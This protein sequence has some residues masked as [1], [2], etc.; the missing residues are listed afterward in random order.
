MRIYFLLLLFLSFSFS[1]VAQT[2]SIVVK[3]IKLTIVGAGALATL[4]G[5]YVYIQKSWW[6]DNASEFHFDDGS[7]LRYA[8][9][10]DKAGHFVG[11]MLISDMFQGSLQWS[12][13]SE[14]KAH[15]Y[16]AAMGSFVQAAIEMKDAYAPHWG[17]SIW[18]FGAGSVGALVPVA[19]RYWKPMEYID[20]K[21]SYAKRSNHYWD[22]GI[23][24]KPYA[25]P[26]PHAY[27]DDYIN[28]TYWVSFFP[29]RDR[30]HHIGLALGFGLDDTQY[31]D[32]TNTKRGGQN[33]FYIALDYDLLQLLKNWDGPTA[34]KVKHWFNYIKL[35]APTIRVSPSVEFYPFF[36]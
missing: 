6:N 24:Q 18:D 15:W 10:V 36:M 2:D 29:L 9:N 20:F 14:K 30:G 31:L 25:P 21:M 23:A 13:V 19:E 22:L 5:S 28:Q 26:H 33:E 11:G 3:P 34:K 27:Q 35:P 32:V 1:S 12:G 7:D 4:G 16:G 8:L 17:F